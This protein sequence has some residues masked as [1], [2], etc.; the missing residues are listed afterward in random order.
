MSVSL[1]K[2]LSVLLIFLNFTVFLSTDTH[3]FIKNVRSAIEGIVPFKVSFE[4]AVV[5]EGQTEIEESGIIYF[6]SQDH[7]KWIYQ[8]PDFKVFLLEGEKYQFYEE[9]NEQ[10]TI[11]HINDS[12]QHW[13]W[14]LIFASNYQDFITCD[15]KDKI[16]TIL[17]KDDDLHVVIYLNDRLLP[18]KVV[19]YDPS[20]LTL[21]HRFKD[22]QARVVLT[23]KDMQLKVPKGIDIVRLQ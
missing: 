5:N 12:K 11:G 2:K 19:Q 21:I 10:L 23:K 22:Y 14:Q 18:R 7:L 20:G 17:N 8:D 3:P 6:K 16:I 15:L 9:D 13:I 1:I 4:A